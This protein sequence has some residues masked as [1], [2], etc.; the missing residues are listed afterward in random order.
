[1]STTTAVSEIE[2]LTDDQRE[3][4]ELCQQ[5]SLVCE[6]CADEC[7]GDETMAE[8]VRRCRDV[9]DVAA[10]HAR[11]LARGSANSDALAAVCADA[12]EACAT[13]CETHDADHCRVCADVLREC[14]RSCAAMAD[15]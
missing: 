3:C 10:L 8:C 7:L 14:A 12:C 1:M 13:E 11:L 5:A 6:W 15:A 2:S 4:V 9:A